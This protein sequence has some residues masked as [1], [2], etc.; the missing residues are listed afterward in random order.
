MVI[1]QVEMAE[2]MF[3]LLNPDILEPM[4]IQVYE[5]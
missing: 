5:H 1:L 4:P 2:A 3:E